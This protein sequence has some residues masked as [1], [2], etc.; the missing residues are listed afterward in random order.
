MH[1]HTHV[2]AINT[3]LQ[4]TKKAGCIHLVLDLAVRIDV[5]D[6]CLFLEPNTLVE[7]WSEPHSVYL[8]QSSIYTE[9]PSCCS[10]FYLWWIM[11][12]HFFYC[13][14]MN[15]TFLTAGGGSCYLR[16][17]QR[18]TIDWSAGRLLTFCPEMTPLVHINGSAA[19][20]KTGNLIRARIWRYDAYH[21]TEVM[22]QYIVML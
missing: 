12:T 22:I 16:I 1:T 9:E 18:G 17:D 14:E 6:P 10:R 8:L 2:H 21:D 13:L 20:V 19:A 4:C 11:H 15:G 7:R 5:S 3:T